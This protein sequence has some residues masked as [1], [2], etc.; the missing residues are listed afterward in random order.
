LGRARD[1][2]HEQIQCAAAHGSAKNTPAG[3]T[4]VVVHALKT[5]C[6]PAQWGGLP[7]GGPRCGA[8]RDLGQ[9]HR[10]RAQP[11]TH[12]SSGRLN[13]TFATPVNRKHGED[14]IITPA[15]TNEEAEKSFPVFK[16]IKPYL[17]TTK[18][19]G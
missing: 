11:R 2:R 9:R 7:A 14:V 4:R 12:R 16:T 15:V 19:P 1:Q 10:R 5:V 18:Q 8:P 3:A 17:R 6:T 13:R